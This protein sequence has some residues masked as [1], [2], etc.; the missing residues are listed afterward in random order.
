MFS[1]KRGEEMLPTNMPKADRQAWFEETYRTEY[2]A[3][4]RYAKTIMKAHGSKYIS[5]EGRAEEAVQEMF[6][7]AWENWDR[8]FASESPTGWLYKTLYYKTRELLREDKKWIKRVLQMSEIVE[9]D[10]EEKYFLKADMAGILTDEE[11]RLLSRLY[12]EG[13]TYIEL[14]EELGLK[15]SALA[16]RI[17][18]IK[19]RFLKEYGAD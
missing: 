19:E 10:R 8:V 5:I 3:M 11:Y 4:I 7:F 15:K 18:R 17:K 9:D 6:V 14:C 12:L 13:Y 16:M 2:L 1:A